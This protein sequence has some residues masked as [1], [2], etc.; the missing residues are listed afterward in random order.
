MQLSNNVSYSNSSS[1]SL[2]VV[3]ISNDSAVPLIKGASANTQVGTVTLISSNQA[4]Q[5]G[6]KAYGQTGPKSI[7]GKRKIRFNALK[8]GQFA[9]SMLLP[10]EDAKLYA[11]HSKAIFSA[12][13][14]SNYVETQLVD[15]YANA[16]W[17]IQ[18]HE[19]RGAYEREKILERLTPAMAAQ[20]LGI[21]GT[22]AA[23]APDYL[24]Q[25]HHVIS[26]TEMK[27]ARVALNQFGYL[28]QNA[29]GIGNFNLVWRQYQELFEALAT[30]VGQHYTKNPL[31]GATGEGLSM[32]W[33]KNPVKLLQC[34]EQMTNELYYIANWKLIQPQV[35][36]WMESYYFLQ[37][38][39]QHRINQDE[40]LL[41][42]E[43][44]YAHGLLD[45]LM[46]QRKSGLLT[47]VIILDG[48]K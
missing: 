18:R 27:S 41:M 29:K 10:F 46:R 22:R 45:R 11:R 2:A 39:E 36:V 37:R 35:R 30:W 19:T 5:D 26:L 21:T 3:S 40:Q 44:N 31:F 47:E 6:R 16:L 15:E 25:L 7:V 24:I 42:K 48:E 4:K 1:Q 38:S 12:L 17:R 23:C 33:Q 13:A 43:R 8:T 32:V 28:M 14:P 9:K 34:L 20:M